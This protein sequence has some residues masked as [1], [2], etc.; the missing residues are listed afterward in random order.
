M[1][2]AAT[3]YALLLVARFRAELRREAS[4]WTAMRTAYRASVAPI[5]AS[6]GTVILGLL[7]LLLS[8][9]NSN[10]GLG[11]IAATG[12]ATSLIAA[13]SFLPAVLG[14]AA[15]WPFRPMVGSASPE[16]RG[17]WAAIVL[18]AGVAFVPQLDADGVAQS[19]LFVD[20]S[21]VDSVQGQEALGRHFPGGTGSPAVIIA[22][23]GAEQAV[24]DAASGVAGVATVARSQAADGIVEIAAVLADAPTARPRSAPCNGCGRPCTPS[25]ALTRWWAG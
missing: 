5:A 19:D 20:K 11:P 10:R 6:V 3:D 8:G 23:A 18:L 16:Q 13:L 24:L 21:S 1:F 4:R 25:R 17:L 9:L 7:C 15:F 14:R 22:N 12:I 2:G